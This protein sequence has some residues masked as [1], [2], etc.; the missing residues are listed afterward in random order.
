MQINNVGV[1]EQ[2]RVYA[3]AI[4]GAYGSKAEYVVHW[5]IQRER[6]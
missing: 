3:F 2:L 4:L 5:P 6:L 1:L